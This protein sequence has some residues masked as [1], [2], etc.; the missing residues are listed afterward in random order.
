MRTF[1]FLLVA[2]PV[3]LFCLFSVL[4]APPHYFIVTTTDNVVSMKLEL[5][6]DK[7]EMSNFGWLWFASWDNDG[8]AGGLIN[9]EYEDGLTSKCSIGYITSG[10]IQPHIFRIEDKKCYDEFGLQDF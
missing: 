3:F 10:Y 9:V 7:V 5:L 2:L 6:D 8:D 1:L 4:F